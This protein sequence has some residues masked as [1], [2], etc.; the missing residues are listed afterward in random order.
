MNEFIGGLPTWPVIIASVLI[1]GVLLW[2]LTRSKE[3]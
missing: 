1:M 2:L 3:V